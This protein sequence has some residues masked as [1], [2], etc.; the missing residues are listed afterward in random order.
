MSHRVLI[1]SSE[2][3]P[4]VMMHGPPHGAVQQ[5]RPLN[6][7]ALIPT[8]AYPLLPPVRQKRLPD[9]QGQHSPLHPQHP[10]I[11]VRVPRTILVCDTS[12]SS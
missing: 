3:Q 7:I 11:H 8:A 5:R 10:Q 12:E 9:E 2:G 1:S 6:P 4:V